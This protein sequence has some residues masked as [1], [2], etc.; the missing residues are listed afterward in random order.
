MLNQNK[1][2]KKVTHKIEK[3]IQSV[4][5]VHQKNMKGDDS[6]ASQRAIHF[7]KPEPSKKSTQN[8]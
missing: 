3:Q 7:D 1:R 4:E 6:V 2:A 5:R 8:Q